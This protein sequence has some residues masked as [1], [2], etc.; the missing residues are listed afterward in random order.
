MAIV[1]LLEKYIKFVPQAAVTLSFSEIA[2][3]ND[4]ELF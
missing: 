2:L 3:N 1:K 4:E